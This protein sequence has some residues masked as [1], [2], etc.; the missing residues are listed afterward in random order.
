M[1]NF[2]E[3]KGFKLKSGNTPLFKQIG[4]PAK[5]YSVEKGSHDHPHGE[6]P[7]TMYGETPVKHTRSR[8]GHMDKYGAGHTNADHDG[9]GETKNYW[10]DKNESGK[11]Q[12]EIEVAADNA[13]N[14]NTKTNTKTNTETNTENKS[15]KKK[16]RNVFS[17]LEKALRI[18]DTKGK[19]VVGKERLR[20]QKEKTDKFKFM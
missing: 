16:K 8:K 19:V 5:N 4:T 14:T 10:K 1:P 20:K 12:K 13:T 6:S 18:K 3:S 7:A 15:T 9:S 17:R 11:T 2:D